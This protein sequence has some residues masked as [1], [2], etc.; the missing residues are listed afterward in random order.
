[1][2]LQ[3]QV[4][5]LR[6]EL[7]ASQEQRAIAEDT[8]RREAEQ[9]AIAE[10]TARREAEQ[11][12]VAED[13]ARREAEQRANAEASQRAAESDVLRDVFCEAEGNVW[14]CFGELFYLHRR[15]AP[16]RACLRGSERGGLF[17]RPA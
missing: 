2:E 1:M 5:K 7:S 12:A 15:V 10:D 14:L 11:R 4:R 3:E 16:W 8:A 6:L 13:T 17:Q 9:R